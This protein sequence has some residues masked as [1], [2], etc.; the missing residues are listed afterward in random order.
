M[1]GIEESP[2]ACVAF[3]A[4]GLACQ[5]SDVQDDEK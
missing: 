3:I 4:A 1:P 5:K 2:W